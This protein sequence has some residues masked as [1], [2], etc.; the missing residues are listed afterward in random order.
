MR[1][2]VMLIAVAAA[3]LMSGCASV[4]RDSTRVTIYG[5]GPLE[6]S[7]PT[8]KVLAKKAIIDEVSRWDKR[9]WFFTSAKDPIKTLEGLKTDELAGWG[10][11]I[12]TH[13]KKFREMTTGVK[14][15][16]GIQMIGTGNPIFTGPNPPRVF[17]TW[18][19]QEKNLPGA[20][21]IEFVAKSEQ[22][23]RSP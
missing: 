4:E 17:T 1:I 19:G 3:L 16:R 9:I 13:I 20:A 22:Q 18:S 7:I 23:D 6:A 11:E 14:G 12:L 8:V 5:S 15:V 10:L 21:R 2:H